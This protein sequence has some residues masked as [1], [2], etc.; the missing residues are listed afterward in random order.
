MIR[1]SETQYLGGL[2]PHP[3]AEIRS[4][5]RYPGAGARRE[6]TG[7]PHRHPGVSFAHL[8]FLQ[9]CSNS[10]TSDAIGRKQPAEPI[11]ITVVPLS[12]M[13]AHELDF[14]MTGSTTRKQAGV[15]QRLRITRTPGADQ[16]TGFSSGGPHTTDGRAI[17]TAKVVS[18]SSPARSCL[19]ASIP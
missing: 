14:E 11:A 3:G 10:T 5:D 7:G 1:T 8:P 19:S 13:G 9:C 6:Q 17:S 2:R 12:M 16:W 15:A 4:W 18:S